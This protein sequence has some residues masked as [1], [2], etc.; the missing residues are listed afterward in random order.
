MANIHTQPCLLSAALTAAISLVL[1][2]SRHS[3][4]AQTVL[5]MRHA[6]PSDAHADAHAEPSPSPTPVT[7]SL[8]DRQR[9]RRP[10][11][12]AD[13]LGFQRRLDRRPRQ[14]ALQ[15]DDHQP[16][17][18]HGAARRQRAGQ[19]QRLHQRVRLGRIVLGRHSR[20]QGADAQ[21]V[22]AG[23][24]RLHP[25]QRGRIQRHQRADRRVRAALRFHRLGIV[26]AVL[27]HRHRAVAVR[28]GALS[29]Q[30]HDEP[31]SRLR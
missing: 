20:P 9:Q 21:S 24:H 16:G 30:L 26:A 6:R 1:A 31:R 15:P 28:E 7:R 27:R 18:R 25:V 10:H 3:A 13:R 2:G 5:A 29:P 12:D 11:S 19:L 4:A 22:A 14:S 23:G 8:A 17:A